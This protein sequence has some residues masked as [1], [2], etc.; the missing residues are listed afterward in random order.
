MSSMMGTLSDWQVGQIIAALTLPNPLDPKHVAPLHYISLHTGNP[1]VGDPTAYELPG[2]S[3]QRQLGTFVI[4]GPRAIRTS[5]GQKW[6]S[7]GETVVT[8]LGIWDDSH[9]GNLRAGIVLVNPVYVTE[10]GSYSLAAGDL[11]YRWP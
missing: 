11:Y 8:H 5:N 4:A 9:V 10:G 2:T 3:Y 7:L 1:L 6:P